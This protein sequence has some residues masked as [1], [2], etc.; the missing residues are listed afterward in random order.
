V[1]DMPS[2]QHFRP[3]AKGHS[4]GWGS[5]PNF[6]NRWMNGKEPTPYVRNNRGQILWDLRFSGRGP[7]RDEA[8]GLDGIVLVD[9][10]KWIEYRH[11]EL[12]LGWSVPNRT[13]VTI[14]TGT[15]AWLACE[16]ASD[17]DRVCFTVHADPASAAGSA[18]TLPAHSDEVSIS[19]SF[20]Q[21]HYQALW[22]LCAFIEETC[23]RVLAPPAD[24]AAQ[25][26][27]DASGS[28]P[29]P[30]DA[31]RPAHSGGSA[32][33]TDQPTNLAEPGR[34]AGPGRAAQPAPATVATLAVTVERVPDTP[35]WVSFAA[36]T[37]EDLLG[38]PAVGT[39]EA[40]WSDTAQQGLPD[41][42][43]EA[44]AEPPSCG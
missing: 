16:P 36:P 20:G 1:I 21:H 23:G 15:V 18:G 24:T 14:A 11:P 19:I 42:L 5:D 6:K 26:V 34:A 39:S 33:G 38:E 41:S 30:A 2:A 22:D 31:A 25:E 27:Q 44:A 13:F 40:S 9:A 4:A 8:D 3:G 32:A 28:E 43:P 29:E 37:A 35:E 10:G 12:I 17:A 7:G